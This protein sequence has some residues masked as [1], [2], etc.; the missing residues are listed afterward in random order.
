MPIA[1][2]AENDADW[3]APLMA[4]RRCMDYWQNAGP[5]PSA[6]PTPPAVE[7]R[8]ETPGVSSKDFGGPGS[9][10]SYGGTRRR[11]SLGRGHI[12][13]RPSL[14][15]SFSGKKRQLAREESLQGAAGKASRPRSRTTSLDEI[16]G[17]GLKKAK[18]YE[19]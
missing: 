9:S 8:H 5:P 2:A 7:A 12:Q 18:E 13:L 1:V 10:S 17:T 15:S 6:A 4:A 11:H 19:E 3:E 14:G 16:S